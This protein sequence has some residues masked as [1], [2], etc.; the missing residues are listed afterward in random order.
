MVDV[1]HDQIGQ[2]LQVRNVVSPIQCPDSR[3]FWRTVSHAKVSSFSPSALGVQSNNSQNNVDNSWSKH[4]GNRC[5]QESK[6]ADS[7][8]STTRRRANA[9]RKRKVRKDDRRCKENNPYPPDDRCGSGESLKRRHFGGDNENCKGQVL[10]PIYNNPNKRSRTINSPRA[11]DQP[12]AKNNLSGY[13]SQNRVHNHGPPDYSNN[14]GVRSRTDTPSMSHSERHRTQPHQQKK[15]TPHCNKSH[16]PRNNIRSQSRQ[17]NSSRSN[18]IN[19]VHESHGYNFC[20]P[21]SSTDVD[22]NGGEWPSLNALRL[23]TKPCIGNFTGYSAGTSSR[24][25]INSSLSSSYGASVSTRTQITY[26]SATRIKWDAAGNRIVQTPCPPIKGAC[27]KKNVAME[28]GIQQ[29]APPTSPEASGDSVYHSAP[30]PVSEVV[31]VPPVQPSAP[32]NQAR[33]KLLTE[34]HTSTQSY[35]PVPQVLIRGEHIGCEESMTNEFK[36]GELLFVHMM[37]VQ[38]KHFVLT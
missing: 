6:G 30:H 22:T 21:G 11:I 24:H 31:A 33:D 12:R 2:T 16:R 36:L 26:P 27:S 38:Q 1:Q 8:S 15:Y 3:E 17:Q 9:R 13:S 7:S 23:A 18:C 35:Q 4:H 29:H 5:Y 34:P 32:D 14:C 20:T 28:R 25:G 19:R 37:C 10:S